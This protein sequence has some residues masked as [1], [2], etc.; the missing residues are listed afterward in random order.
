[1]M[2]GQTNRIAR[3][4]IMIALMLVLGW[5]DRAIPLGSILG[6]SLPGVKLG[7]ANTVLLY[8][9]YL[10]NPGSALLLLTA[11]VLLS[12][13]L[14]GSF[15]AILYSLSG[16]ILSLAA[17]LALRGQNPAP[18]RIILTSVAGAMAHNLGQILM[19]AAVA[20]TP[21]LLT[22]YLLPLE[23]IGAAV[24]CV[25]GAAA[26]RVIRAVAGRREESERDGEG[27]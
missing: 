12:G 18:G 26:W 16:G 25:T 3:L 19:A 14:F 24:G 27:A 15:S 1:M 8:A 11:K 5:L 4:S 6:G 22:A 9:V 10:M 7:L 17:M 21:G 20:G 23:G 13:W 2:S